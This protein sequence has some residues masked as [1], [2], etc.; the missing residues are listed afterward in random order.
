MISS[1][2]LSRQQHLLKNDAVGC[3]DRLINPLL[4]LQL[5][6]LGAPVTATASLSQTWTNTTHFI[7]IQFGLSEESYSYS[8]ET[9]LFVPGQG[10]TIGPFLWLLSF[11]LI[12]DIIGTEGPS[13]QFASVDGIIS[14]NNAGDAFADDSYLGSSS[15]YALAEDFTFHETQY[16]HQNSAVNNLKTISRKWEKLLFSTGCNQYVQKLLGSYG[17]ALE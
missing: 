8:Q 17:V 3:Y 9:P 7:R 13:I 12:A 11:C 5:R 14:I 16:N 2:K 6:R 1:A 10:S 4:L 15:T